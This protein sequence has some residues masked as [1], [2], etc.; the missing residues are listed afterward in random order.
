MSISN[1]I[2][3]GYVLDVSKDDDGKISLLSPWGVLKIPNNDSFSD[4]LDDVQD[5]LIAMHKAKHIDKQIRN[6]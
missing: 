1:C 6:W 3:D 5:F 2:F 4:F